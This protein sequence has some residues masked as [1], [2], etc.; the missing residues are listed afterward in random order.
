M[1]PNTAKPFQPPPASVEQDEIPGANFLEG[2]AERRE[3]LAAEGESHPLAADL[4]HPEGSLDS[5]ADPGKVA[6][7]HN[8]GVRTPS[9]PAARRHSWAE[10]LQRVFEVDAL[11]CPSCGE[12]MRLMAAITDPMIA[13]RILK[14]LGLPPR[15]PPSYT[16]G[17]P[18]AHRDLMVLRA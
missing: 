10:L 14:C 12:R 11:R 7:D 9:A 13:R 1:V 15:A 3:P 18:R 5:E 4:I 16:G 8:K 2:K 17:L 6:V